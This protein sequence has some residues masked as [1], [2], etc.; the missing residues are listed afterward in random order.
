MRMINASPYDTRTLRRLVVACYRELEKVEGPAP[1]WHRLH[2]YVKLARERTYV[3]YCRGRAYLNG[4]PVTLLLPNPR[5]SQARLADAARVIRHELLHAYGY[6]HGQFQEADLP[7][8][9][10]ARYPTLLPCKAPRPPRPKADRAAQRYGRVL[11][12][13]GAWGRK[14]KLAQTKLRRYRAERLRYERRM[15]ARVAQTYNVRGVYSTARA[16]VPFIP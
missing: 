3:G 6:R 10:L 2:V 13:E 7:D 11:A 5:R 12:L 9:V 15:A 14:L 16:V 4:G 8:R 1:W